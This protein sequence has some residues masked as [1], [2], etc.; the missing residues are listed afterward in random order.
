VDI[1]AIVCTHNRA[2]SLRRTLESLAAAAAPAGLEW[3][4]LVVDNASADATAETVARLRDRFRLCRYLHEPALGLSRARNAGIRQARGRILAFL[5]D[6]VVVDGGWLCAL[7][8]AYAR[9]DAA[10]VSGRV[11]LARDLPRPAWWHERFDDPLGKFDRGEAV[12]LSSESAAGVLGIGAN[13][14]FRRDVFERHGPFRTDLGRRGRRLAMGEETELC[15][16]LRRQGELVVH[17]PAALVYHAPDTTRFT[18][19]YLRRWYFRMGEWRAPEVLAEKGAPRI[20]GVPRWRYGRALREAVAALRQTCLSGRNS[21]FPHEAAVFEFLGTLSGALRLAVGPAPTEAPSRGGARLLPAC[22]SAT[23]LRNP[24][25]SAAGT[26]R[27]TGS[28]GSR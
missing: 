11:L 21:A 12:T 27:S 6:D 4:V 18:K 28:T 1:T 10:C 15:N 14:S 16:R 2:G 26:P 3:E 19:R 22:P 25:G 5:D 8:E 20:L 7:R 13:I 9:Y 24:D 23:S 17:Y